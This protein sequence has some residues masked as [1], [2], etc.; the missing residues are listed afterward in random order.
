M[1]K[2]IVIIVRKRCVRIETKRKNND[3]VVSSD[4]F[5]KKLYIKIYYYMKEKKISND[6]V[7]EFMNEY[8]GTK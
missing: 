5:F 6:N 8:S 1:K 7:I 3:Y 2:L 4:N